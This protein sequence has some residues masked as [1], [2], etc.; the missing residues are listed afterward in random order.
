MKKHFRDLFQYNDWANQRVLITLE[1]S[2]FKNEKLLLLFSHLLSAQI[3]WLNRIK[4]IPTSPFPIWEQYKLRELR[5]MTEES[6]SNWLN[7]LDTHKFETFEEMV[8]YKNSNGRKFENTIREIINQV[9]NHSSYHRGQIAS[10]LK[11][12]GI[13]PPVTDYIAYARQK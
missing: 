12:E 7:Y 5:S 2:D 8:F 9:I 4:D 3:V 11:E 6:S 1:Q 10:L 13:E